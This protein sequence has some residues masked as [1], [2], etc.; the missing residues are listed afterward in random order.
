MCNIITTDT[1]INIP[2]KNA[3]FAIQEIITVIQRT[4]FIFWCAT[5]A[6]TVI[7]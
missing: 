7:T 3:I 2:G 4:L 5:S 1:E 6:T